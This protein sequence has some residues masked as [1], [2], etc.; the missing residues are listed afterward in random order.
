M[1]AHLGTP[2]DDAL[3]LILRIRVVPVVVLNDAKDAAPLGAA[4]QAG[5]LP[6]AEVTLRTAA[7]LESLRIM[8]SN[9]DI[10]A[11]AGTVITADQVDSAVAAGARFIV[12]PGFSES[13]VERAREH[14][15][16]VIPGI[17]TAT[18]LIQAVALGI[19]LV[20]F[21]PAI[22]LGGIPAIQALS[23]AFPGVRFVPTGGVSEQNASQFLAVDSVVAVGGSWMVPSRLIS[24]GDFAGIQR[25][26]REATELV[27]A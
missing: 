7:A 20:K 15:V 3:A 8:S 12:S 26:A 19:D 24:A 18:E 23:S 16:P 4:L 11:G 2:A 13:V 25:L 1:T 21:F 9:P 14:A 22:P 10:V 5:G 17:A 6:L 27:S